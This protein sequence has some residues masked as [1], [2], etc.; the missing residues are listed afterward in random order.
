[1]KH[2]LFF[3]FSLVLLL[4]MVW[5]QAQNPAPPAPAAGAAQP[6]PAAMSFTPG[7]LIRAQLEK[8]IDTKKAQVGDQVTAKTL[9]DLQSVPPGLAL[10]GCQII[11]HVIEV[12]AHQ[13]DS[14]SVLKIAF[15]KMIL[16]NGSEMPLPATIKA[17]GYAD[18]FDP[19]SNTDLATRMGGGLGESGT[20]R[21]QSAAPSGPGGSSPGV[22]TSIGSGGGNPNMYGGGRMPTAGAANP[23]AKMPLNAKGAV[24]MSGVSLEDSGLIS[25]KHNVKLEGGM[26]MIL[27]T[28]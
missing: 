23:D 6:A 3:L 20:G 17:V 13:G 24:G 4:G 8:S 10:K 12:S 18:Q 2:P 21:M 15:D 14:P 26:Q 22:Q 7:T 5:A 11:G 28:N 19:A 9:D 25:K 1:M 16:K 27:K